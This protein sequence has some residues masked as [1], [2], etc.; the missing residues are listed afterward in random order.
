[1]SRQVLRFLS[2][3]HVLFIALLVIL[4]NPYTGGC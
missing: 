2:R 4:E 3:N 1:M